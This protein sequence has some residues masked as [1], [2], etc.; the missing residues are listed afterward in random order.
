MCC[1]NRPIEEVS[2][3][4]IL[5][6]PTKD[7][8]QVTV[9]EN[10]LDVKGGSR[11]KDQKKI[12]AIKEK[13]EKQKY[14]NA[15]ILPCPLKRGQEIKVLDFSSDAFKFDRLFK[16]FPREVVIN[17]QMEKIAA[18]RGRNAQKA[19]E[20]VEVGAYFVSLATE[21]D[22]LDRID[23]NVFK[24]SS[25]IKELFTKH[26]FKGFGFVICCFNPEK[27]VDPHPIGYIHDLKDDGTMFVPC[28][29]EHGH[30]EKP[31]EKF[32][33]E[34]YSLNT[35]DGDEAGRTKEDIVSIK[36]PSPKGVEIKIVPY[37][38]AP[39]SPL[40]ALESN[41]LAPHLPEI[42]TFRQRIIHG[43]HKNADLIFTLA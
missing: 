23:P 31:V 5:V 37:P 3:T 10:V 20:V 28:R 13:Q 39:A 6:F 40:A 4:K 43:P 24:V 38:D 30:G 42:R 33:H 29:H 9:Y 8:R 7:G 2:K 12:E 16:Y 19:L 18:S 14:E 34:I 27:K 35:K 1:F 17:L 15:M 21:L 11:G 32:D 26:Y 25:N 41:V 36:A 22:D